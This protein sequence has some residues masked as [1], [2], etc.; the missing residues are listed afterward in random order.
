MRLTLESFP[1]C[2]A[3]AQQPAAAAFRVRLF[4]G[5]VAPFL[6][7]VLVYHFLFTFRNFIAA[8]LSVVAKG[9]AAREHVLYRAIY[10][11]RILELRLDIVRAAIVARNTSRKRNRVYVSLYLSQSKVS[12]LILCNIRLLCVSPIVRL[13]ALKIIR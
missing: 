1:V 2:S 10:I 3:P 6:S 9:V 8:I 11:S 7:S 13:S 4:L 5:L 12:I